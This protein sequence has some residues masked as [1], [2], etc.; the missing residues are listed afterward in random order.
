MKIRFWILASA[1][2]F[3]SS[4]AHSRTFT[5]EG[6]LLPP[7]HGY[8][9]L[10]DRSLI[11]D[12]SFENG[13]C[14][15][16]LSTW[17][18]STDNE[19]DWIADLVPLGLW[20][21]DGQHVAWLGGYCGQATC[22]TTICKRVWIDGSYLSWFWF[23]YIHNGGR[24]VNVSIDGD[25]VFTYITDLDDHLLDWDSI[26]VWTNYYP[27]WRELCFEYH[28]E[29]DCRLNIGDNYFI[30]FVE[31]TGTQPTSPLEFSTVRSRD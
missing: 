16:G 6:G 15:D 11:S 22:Y 3:L 25:I 29:A 17:T 21:Y 10:S 4:S 24:L 7:S 12:G 28:N 9:F 30:D 1:I 18:C 26:G 19:C 5:A 20:N 23:G 27:D 8:T 31:I 2:V 14:S 13:T